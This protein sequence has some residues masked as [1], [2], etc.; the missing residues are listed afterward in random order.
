MR[1]ALITSIHTTVLQYEIEDLQWGFK[2]LGHE[3]EIIHEDT[4]WSEY[5]RERVFE[6]DYCMFIEEYK[7]DFIMQIDGLRYNHGW[8]SLYKDIPWVCWLQDRLEWLYDKNLIKLITKK[9]ICL[10]ICPLFT[11]EYLDFGYPKDCMHDMYYGVNTEKYCLDKTSNDDRFKCD[12]AFVTRYDSLIPG[13]TKWLEEM[14]EMALGA[15]PDIA[16]FG[17]G[18]DK[19]RFKDLYRGDVRPGPELAKLYRQPLLHLHHN[20]QLSYHMR[21]LQ[22][23]SSGG[24]VSIHNLANDN[25]EQPLPYAYLFGDSNALDRQLSHVRRFRDSGELETISQHSSDWIKRHHCYTKRCR[26]IIDMVKAVA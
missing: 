3:A 18:W 10:S 23:L 25:R 17:K 2:K 12:I 5:N 7:P 19:S 16:L 24:R 6:D 4:K 11:K 1:V 26:Q 13:R 15:T 8:G 9:D 20:P 21:P 22:C 14:V